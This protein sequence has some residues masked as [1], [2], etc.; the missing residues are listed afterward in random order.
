ME[1]LGRST[2]VLQLFRMTLTFL[3]RKNSGTMESP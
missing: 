3:D 1:F 2:V